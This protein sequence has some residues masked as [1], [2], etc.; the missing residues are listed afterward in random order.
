MTER[1]LAW[2]QTASAR[3]S[4]PVSGGQCHSSPSPHHPQ[5][6]LL[7]QFSL[8]VHK[9]GGGVSACIKQTGLPEQSYQLKQSF[10]YSSNS[11][12]LVRTF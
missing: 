9:G 5:E 10:M 12:L 1:S 11:I 8:Y 7:A 2:P 4:N 6:V 3:V